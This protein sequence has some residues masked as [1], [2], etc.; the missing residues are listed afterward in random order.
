MS[1]LELGRE[2]GMEVFKAKGLSL[3]G[4]KKDWTE[5]TEDADSNEWLADLHDL[6]GHST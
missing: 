1:G 3:L 5:C 2:K 6:C 4:G